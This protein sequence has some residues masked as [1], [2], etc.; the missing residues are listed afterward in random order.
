MQA[1]GRVDNCKVLDALIEQFWSLLL[2][3]QGKHPIVITIMPRLRLLLLPVFIPVAVNTDSLDGRFLSHLALARRY[4]IALATS[5]E[6]H[7]HALGRS[8]M[9]SNVAF[10]ST[11]EAFW[12]AG[13]AALLAPS[14]LWR[15][16]TF[17]FLL[18]FGLTFTRTLALTGLLIFGLS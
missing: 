9:S 3:F 16:R 8:A 14:F 10:A 17:V 2:H 18:S 7:H 15:F 1:R 12:D 5:L 13:V 4:F 6:H 11:P